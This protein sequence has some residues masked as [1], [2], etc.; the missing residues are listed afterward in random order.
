MRR[1][2]GQRRIRR[3]GSGGEQLRSQALGL[4]G[5]VDRSFPLGA[6]IVHDVRLAD[7]E[8]IKV[9]EIR[10]GG[11]QPHAAGLPVTVSAKS[12]DAVVIFKILA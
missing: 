1:R 11:I 10:Q 3:S 7:G 9:S 12:D 8:T 2:N 5:V 6:A 4:A